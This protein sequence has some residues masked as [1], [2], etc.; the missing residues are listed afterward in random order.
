MRLIFDVIGQPPEEDL[1]FI[2]DPKAVMYI[3]SFSDIQGTGLSTL[4]PASPSDAIDL[5]SRLLKFDPNKRITLD[6]VLD[7]PYFAR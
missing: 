1:Q 4:F 5:L 7:H 3:K 6:E 2:T